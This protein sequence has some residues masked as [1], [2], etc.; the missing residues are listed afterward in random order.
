MISTR[1]IGGLREY[2]GRISKANRVFQHVFR[3]SD[4][5]K[6]FVC[7]PN[8]RFHDLVSE[9]VRMIPTRDRTNLR[10]VKGGLSGD[11]KLMKS[12]VGGIFKGKKSNTGPIIEPIEHMEQVCKVPFAI[13]P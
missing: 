3:K 13:K 6:Y 8:Y 1:S 7:W 12:L 5:V 9:H 10:T 4:I 2:S 11:P